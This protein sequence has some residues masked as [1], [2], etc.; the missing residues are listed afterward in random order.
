ML[1]TF[2]N[3]RIPVVP[4]MALRCL[5]PLAMLTALSVTGTTL[6]YVL[7]LGP[8][9]QRR[10]GAEQAYQTAKLAQSTLQAARTQ[11]VRARAAQRQLDLVR[12]ALPAQDEFT[13]L[14]MALGELGKSEHVIIPGMNYDVKTAEGSYPAKATIAF[15][16]SGDYAAVYRFL[17]RLET[18]EPYLVIESLDVGSEHKKDSTARVVV[19]IKV[20]TYLRQTEGRP[21]S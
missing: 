20:A 9:Q 18:V 15:R 12:Q 3:L 2:A 14:A 13:P 16:A 1:M 5:L 17:H 19:N 11:Q 21:A 7:C 6:A 4:M 8:A 10:A